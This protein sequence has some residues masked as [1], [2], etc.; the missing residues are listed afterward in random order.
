[1]FAFG[2]ALAYCR[3]GFVLIRIKDLFE[4]FNDPF[5][6][7]KTSPGKLCPGRFHLFRLAADE[8]D[9]NILPLFR[10]GKPTGDLAAV[11]RESV[12]GYNDGIGQEVP[13]PEVIP[14]APVA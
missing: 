14:G 11:G 12:K 13:Q 6:S 4:R 2:R 1:Y 8:D 3:L 9:R 7:T 5:A 10:F